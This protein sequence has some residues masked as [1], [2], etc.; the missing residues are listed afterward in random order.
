M[1]AMD[2]TTLMMLNPAFAQQMKMFD[3]MQKNFWGAFSTAGTKTE[4]KD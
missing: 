2:P 1:E 4:K 3:A